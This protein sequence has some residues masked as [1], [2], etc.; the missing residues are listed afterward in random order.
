MTQMTQELTP[1]EEREVKDEAKNQ[2]ECLFEMI[3]D[4]AYVLCVDLDWYT[5]E[6]I[7]HIEKLREDSE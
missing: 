7:K 6:V 5:D 3:K 2:A 4:Q 1:E